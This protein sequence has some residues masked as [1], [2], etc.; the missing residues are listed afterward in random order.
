M[1]VIKA[2]IAPY[3]AFLTLQKEQLTA[4]IR[5]LEEEGRQDEADLEKVR[6]NITTVFETLANA[7]E[8]FCKDDYAAFCERYTARFTTMPLSWQAHLD[9]AKAHGDADA[10][11]IEEAKLETA[12][13]LKNAFL[14]RKE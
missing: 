6:L 1:T 7:D 9:K 11:R 12:D 14:H 2:K 10:Q 13:Q 8:A 5:T 3:R 4:S